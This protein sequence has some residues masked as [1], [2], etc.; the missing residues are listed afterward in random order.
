MNVCLLWGAVGWAFGVKPSKSCFSHLSLLIAGGRGRD[1][2]LRSGLP[3]ST[4]SQ[5]WQLADRDIGGR[6]NPAEFAVALFL[7]QRALEG[8]APPPVLPGPL[9][10][11]MEAVLS[12]SL[13]VMDDRH[14]VKCQTAFAAF[15]ACIVTGTLGCK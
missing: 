7:V 2:F 14:V 10:E 5:I 4:L 9:V 15:K 3:P 12:G 1:F 13:P 8:V 11:T 6:L